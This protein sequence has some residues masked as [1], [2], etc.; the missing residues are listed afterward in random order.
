MLGRQHNHANGIFLFFIWITSSQ[1]ILTLTR[2]RAGPFPTREAAEAALAALKR[3]S[4]DGKVVA[5]P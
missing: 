2:L 4:L 5:L 3:A 1:A